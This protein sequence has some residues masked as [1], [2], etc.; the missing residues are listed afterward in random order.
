MVVASDGLWEFISNEEVLNLVI[1]A[2]IHNN[3][4]EAVQILE[5]KAV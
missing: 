5:Q 2:F 1:P 4:D 3:A